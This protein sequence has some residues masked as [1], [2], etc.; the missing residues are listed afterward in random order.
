MERLKAAISKLQS[1]EGE[2]DS[3]E[4][5]SFLCNTKSCIY[6]AELYIRRGWLLSVNSLRL[7]RRNYKRYD[8]CLLGR[9]VKLLS[10]KGR[11]TKF[12]HELNSL[13]TREGS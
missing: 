10:C 11:L 8:C 4:K 6:T 7:I 2:E 1:E 5:V 3:E 12:H 9:I 13:S